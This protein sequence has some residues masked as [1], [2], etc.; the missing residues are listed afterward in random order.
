MPG[1]CFGLSTEVGSFHL[2]DLISWLLVVSA[3]E[4]I[5]ARLAEMELAFQASL[6]RLLDW[7][8]LNY[9][10]NFGLQDYTELA[11][12]H[13]DASPVL[14]TPALSRNAQRALVRAAPTFARCL[15]ARVRRTVGLAQDTLGHALVQL[16]TAQRHCGG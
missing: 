16:E 4:T 1:L 5:S 11:Q 8:R 7:H 15:V 14:T 10:S 13:G 2:V 12:A 3:Q 9:L 6:L